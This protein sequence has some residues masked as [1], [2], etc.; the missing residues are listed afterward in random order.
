MWRHPP[1]VDRAVWDRVLALIT[2]RPGLAELTAAKHAVRL[3]TPSTQTCVGARRLCAWLKL[4]MLLPV[5]EQMRH[6]PRGTAPPGYTRN[7]ITKTAM[8][9]LLL[10]PSPV[11]TYFLVAS[12][13]AHHFFLSQFYR[14]LGGVLDNIHNPAMFKLYA[15]TCLLNIAVQFRGWGTRRDL[16]ITG[17]FVT[18]MFYLAGK[19]FEHP[20]GMLEFAR[21]CVQSRQ[22]ERALLWVGRYE[23]H[24]AAGGEPCIAGRVAYTTELR[25]MSVAGIRSVEEGTPLILGWGTED[26]RSV[27]V[28][29]RGMMGLEEQHATSSTSA[30]A[31]AEDAGEEDAGESKCG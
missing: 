21:C 29:A 27:L 1:G 16:V 24:V 8:Q 10:D 19:D 20:D 26:P 30:T 3:L 22:F 23:D 15:G 28:E 25:I 7:K 2:G 4:K 6:L 12:T 5:M 17:K 9:L 31:R 18:S 14:D 11:D 13:V